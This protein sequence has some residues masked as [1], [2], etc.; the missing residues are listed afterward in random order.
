MMII[1]DHPQVLDQVYSSHEDLKSEP[2][3]PVQK[4]SVLQN[5]D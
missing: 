3:Y 5:T 2:L 4:K 1:H